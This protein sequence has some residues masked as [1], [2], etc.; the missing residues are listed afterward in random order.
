MI[1]GVEFWVL[2]NRIG[3]NLFL[4]SQPLGQQDVLHDTVVGMN[5]GFGFFCLGLRLTV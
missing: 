4:T 1:R 5:G 2:A 3:A